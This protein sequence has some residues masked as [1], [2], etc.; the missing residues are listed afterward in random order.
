MVV[1]DVDDELRRDEHFRV[2]AETAL[3][4]T[5]ERQQDA[6]GGVVRWLPPQIAEGHPRVLARERSL[7]GEVHHG[8]LA[9]VV[10]RQLHRQEGAERVAVRVLVRGDEEAV[11]RADRLRDRVSPRSSGASSSM[12]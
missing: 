6:L 4:R 3:V 7:A 8:V 10:E 9:E 11:V 12:S 5:V 1:V 2:G